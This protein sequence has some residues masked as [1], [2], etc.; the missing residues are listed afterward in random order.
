MLDA[1]TL[2]WMDHAIH[3]QFETVI[4]FLLG[5][6]LIAILAFALVAIVAVGPMVLVAAYKDLRHRVEWDARLARLYDEVDRG[7]PRCDKPGPT[8]LE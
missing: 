4:F 3:H 2:R 1:E 8:G 7:R 6:C 5:C